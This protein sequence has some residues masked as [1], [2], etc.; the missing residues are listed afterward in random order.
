MWGGR[1]MLLQ[2]SQFN[3]PKNVSS[4]EDANSRLNAIKTPSVVVSYITKKL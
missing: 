2:P 4:K 1:K 3:G